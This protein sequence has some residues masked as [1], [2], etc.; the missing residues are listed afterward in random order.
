[1]TA[2]E[3]QVLALRMDGLAG[4]EIADLLGIAL[5]TVKATQHHAVR[6]LGAR[7]LRGAFKKYRVI[8]FRLT[9]NV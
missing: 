1:M 9:H 4:K 3:E 6:K 8:R 5:G 2:R 7:T